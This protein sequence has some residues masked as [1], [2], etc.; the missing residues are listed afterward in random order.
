MGIMRGSTL[1]KLAALELASDRVDR[2]ADQCMKAFRQN[3]K[4]AIAY[5]ESQAREATGEASKIWFEVRN[6]LV[7]RRA[8]A[9][10]RTG[11]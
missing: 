9:A 11:S 7:A 10:R 6:L 4:S 3:Y 2:L 8:D 5:A 1:R